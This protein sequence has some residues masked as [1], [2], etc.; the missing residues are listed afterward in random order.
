MRD[1]KLTFLAI[2]LLIIFSAPIWMVKFLPLSDYPSHLL[3]IDIIREY[4]NPEFNF[5]DNFVINWKPI[6]N[7][8]SDVFILLLS[9][10]V[11]IQTAGKIYLNLFGILFILSIFFFLGAVNRRKIFLG[12][13]GFL[14][15][16]NWYFNNGYLNFYG[17]LSIF[18]FS[19]GF[20][21]RSSKLKSPRE[22]F[23]FGFLTVILFFFHLFSYAALI[24]CLIILGFFELKNKTKIKST[25]LALVPSL[26]LFLNY[27]FIIKADSSANL[28]I[29]RLEGGADFSSPIDSIIHFILYT[30]VSF[31]K[32]DILFYLI[33]LSIMGYLL[34]CNLRSNGKNEIERRLAWLFGGLIIFFFIL[35]YQAAAVWPFNVRLNLFILFI[36]L[37]SVSTPSIKKVKKLILPS[38]IIFSL[39]QLIY[40]SFVYHRLSR[41]IETY[42]SGIEYIQPNR[43]ILPLS[44]DVY[45]GC[46]TITPLSTT[47]AY[48]HMAK[49]GAGPYLFHLPHGQIVNY[50]RP[51]KEAFPAPGLYPLRIEEFDMAKHSAPYDY[52]LIWGD[53]RHG[54]EE[55]KDEFELLYKNGDLKLFE[56][57]NNRMA[58]P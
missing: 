18:F 39:A 7:L 52:F 1:K 48:Y 56:R 53:L 25:L 33:P 21:I 34:I 20:W 4:D 31:S 37:A 29:L 23:L 40:T 35:P 42:A 55:L 22:V 12:F 45:G 10:L 3:S 50:R 51:V 27:F 8:A 6:P 19:L 57:K 11:P 13:F 46:A 16:F 44:T 30:F 43:N 38:A 54:E 28:R 32:K 5:K 24:L 9:F 49:G 36:G 58:L 41:K 17:S 2:F 14:F 26:L 15:F 47:W